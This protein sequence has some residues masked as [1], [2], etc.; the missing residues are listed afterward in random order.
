MNT[1]VRIDYDVI[2]VLAGMSEDG[3]PDFL[4]LIV[5]MFLKS[6]PLILDKLKQ[7]EATG[8]LRFLQ[9]SSH[10]LKSSSATLG[11]VALANLCADLETRVRAGVQEDAAL[12]VR[13]IALEF[14]AVQP[15]LESLLADQDRSY[16]TASQGEAV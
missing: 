12:L 10:D 13:N 9:K 4:C 15:V 1:A 16:L 6:A 2:R 3:E 11:A 8:D 7:S 14:E 5:S